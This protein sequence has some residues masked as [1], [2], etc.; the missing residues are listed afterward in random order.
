MR[1]NSGTEA[2]VLRAR[3]ARALVRMGRVKRRSILTLNLGRRNPDAIKPDRR[4]AHKSF[5]PLG[6][7]ADN[8][9]I[10]TSTR[11]MGNI[12]RPVLCFALTIISHSPESRPLPSYHF[13]LSI[14]YASA[15]ANERVLRVY[16][17]SLCIVSV[18][19]PAFLR[20]QCERTLLT[21]RNLC[22]Q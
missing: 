11:R 18:I 9:Q 20:V 19:P 7:V 6:H 1:T 14:W 22:T 12:A 3:G 4:G 10:W 16:R 5:L 21:V 17:A 15:Q 13:L 8:P 2:I